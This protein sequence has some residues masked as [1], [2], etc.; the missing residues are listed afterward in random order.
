VWLGITRLDGLTNEAFRI[1]ER[2]AIAALEKV[3]ET[4]GGTITR[5]EDFTLE[6]CVCPLQCWRLWTVLAG[7]PRRTNCRNGA[8][9]NFQY[10]SLDSPKL[11]NAMN[12]IDV[13]AT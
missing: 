2:P 13:D 12:L 11:V 1:I 10:V 7:V 5:Q 3:S 9:A 8:T 6:G 4:R